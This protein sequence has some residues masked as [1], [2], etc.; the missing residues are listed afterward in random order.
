MTLLSIRHRAAFWRVWRSWPAYAFHAASVT[1]GL[2]MPLSAVRALS[3]SELLPRIPFANAHRLPAVHHDH[4]PLTFAAKSAPAVLSDQDNSH[5]NTLGS[6]EPTAS[7]GPRKIGQSGADQKSQ[8]GKVREES[9]P[10]KVR[11]IADYILLR[12]LVTYQRH[13]FHQ[14]GSG[15]LVV[16]HRSQGIDFDYEEFRVTADL[17]AVRFGGVFYGAEESGAKVFGEWP[18]ADR[19]YIGTGFSAVTMRTHNERYRQDSGDQESRE[20]KWN[21]YALS[22]YLLRSRDH[23]ELMAGTGLSRK[24]YTRQERAS[25]KPAGDDNFH[26]DFRSGFGELRASAVMPLSASLDLLLSYSYYYERMYEGVQIEGSVGSAV[27]G[28]I[29]N[30]YFDVLHIRYTH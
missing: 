6:D 19:T 15:S 2:S 24:R 12:G 23:Y 5:G 4:A 17:G 13:A 22:A 8:F 14:K 26:R 28:V 11:F 18:I 29:E 27:D 20:D 21:N 9:S 16:R 3:Y 7:D 30:H 10:P 25:L 1:F